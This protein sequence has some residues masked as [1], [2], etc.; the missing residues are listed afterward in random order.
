MLLTQ[1]MAYQ[2][3]RN[4]S[5]VSG[6]QPEDSVRCK[7]EVLVRTAP[8][9]RKPWPCWTTP[10]WRGGGPSRGPAGA[11]LQGGRFGQ[12]RQRRQ[13]KFIRIGFAAESYAD[14][15]FKP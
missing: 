2:D 14:S 3:M 12:R 4:V 15:H 10:A 13:D 1:E 6:G 5:V 8:R 7:A 9:C 11:V